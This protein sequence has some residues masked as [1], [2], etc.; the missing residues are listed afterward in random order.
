MS[1]RL[2][3]LVIEVENLPGFPEFHVPMGPGNRLPGNLS[4]AYDELTERKG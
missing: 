2:P 3:G 1:K 4:T